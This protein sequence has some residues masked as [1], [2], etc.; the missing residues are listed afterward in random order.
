MALKRVAPGVR[1][2]DIRSLQDAIAGLNNIDSE[3]GLTALAGGGQDGA[4]QLING[5]N[6]VAVCATNADSVQLPPAIEGSV[7][8]VSNAG[9]ADLTVFGKEGRPDTI[10]GTAGATGVSQADPLSAVYFCPED[11]KWFRVLSA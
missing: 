1:L 2:G 6:T 5:L 3:N 8:F 10:N 4:T 9:A 7:V 11:T